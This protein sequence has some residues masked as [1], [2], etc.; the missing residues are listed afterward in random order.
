[1]AILKNKT[2][3][4]NLKHSCLILMSC[5]HEMSKILK[6]GISAGELDRFAT[7][8]IRS[9]GGEPSFLGYNGFKYAL[10]TS[11]DNEV[12][13]GIST[14]SKIIPNNCLVSLDLGVV[15]KGMYSDSAKT[16]IVGEVTQKAQDLV[17]YTEK[18][19]LEGIKKIKAGSRIGDLG[20]AINLVAQKHGFGNVMEL[21]GHGVG[22]A[23][24]EEPWIQ[25]A[26][27]PGKGARLF[28]NQV[29]AIEPMFT[30]G[31]GEVDFDSTNNDGWT[32]RTK[33]GSLS[34][35]FEHTILVTKR[36]CEVLTDIPTSKLLA[37]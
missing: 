19:L 33:D 25:H 30:T 37:Q 13:H 10:C 2:D 27:T 8:F 24:H 20:Y 12:V 15:Y 11:V 16:Y 9:H 1:M 7:S 17:T 32:V 5:F 18:S 3:L 14:D 26:G 31:S 21:G 34:A 22:Y 4:E 29:I 23:V 28:E 35:H 36:G 6:P